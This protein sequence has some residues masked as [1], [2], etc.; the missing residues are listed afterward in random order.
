MAAA[1]KFARFLQRT[2]FVSKNYYSSGNGHMRSFCTIVQQPKQL[3]ITKLGIIG[4]AAGAI[5]G[6]TY[7]YYEIGKARK[8]IDLEGTQQETVLLKHKPPIAPSRK[9]FLLIT[10]RKISRCPLHS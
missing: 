9:V 7:A 2:Q 1:H 10:S 3:S 4:A 5:I 8:N 6:G